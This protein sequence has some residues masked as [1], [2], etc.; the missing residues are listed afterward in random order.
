MEP[1]DGNIPGG[2]YSG[3]RIKDI[4]NHDVGCKIGHIKWNVLAYVDDI[5]LMATSLIG[6]QE[7]INILGESI[8]KNS[9]KISWVIPSKH[10]ANLPPPQ[11]ESISI[12][13]VQNVA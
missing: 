3:H 8:K 7:L 6:L 10:H 13:L 4:V 9:L 2:E 1:S 11:K 5:V 12:F